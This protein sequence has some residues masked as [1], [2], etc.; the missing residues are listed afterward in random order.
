MKPF[1]REYVALLYTNLFWG[2]EKQRVV[3]PVEVLATATTATDDLI[4]QSRMS[5]GKEYNEFRDWKVLMIEEVL[6][7]LHEALTKTFPVVEIALLFRV[8]WGYKKHELVNALADQRFRR[9]CN[10]SLRQN[11]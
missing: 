8:F 3:I 9:R 10:C 4:P 1:F 5:Y 7:F 11:W 2:N 6:K